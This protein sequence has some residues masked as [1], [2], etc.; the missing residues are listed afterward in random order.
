MEEPPIPPPP[1]TTTDDNDDDEEDDDEDEDAD[2]NGDNPLGPVK[3]PTIH[4]PTPVALA[5]QLRERPFATD[6]AYGLHTWPSAR[7]LAR[8]LHRLGT[9]RRPGL[10]RGR[11][12][13]ELGCGCVFKGGVGG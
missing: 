8:C 1:P 11:S 5:V 13:I 9:Q 6:P 7:K 2:L 10:F 3:T 4:F 12:V